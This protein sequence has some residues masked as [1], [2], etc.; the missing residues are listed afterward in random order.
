MSRVKLI[1][2]DRHILYDEK[3]QIIV[4]AEA[5]KRTVTECI[6]EKIKGYKGTHGQVEN[7]INNEHLENIEIPDHGAKPVEQN[8]HDEKRRDL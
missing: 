4:D 6:R 8:E 2:G 1:G 5:N 7:H 3:K